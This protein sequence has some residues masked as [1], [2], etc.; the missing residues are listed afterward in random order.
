[1]SFG[2]S[3]GD[4]VMF[5]RFLVQVRGALKGDSG[6]QIQ[7]SRAMKQC[8]DF[9][10]ILGDVSRLDLSLASGTFKERLRECSFDTQDVIKDFRETVARYEKS[11]GEASTR[12]KLTSAP[13]KIQ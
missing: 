8:T 4:I 10:A 9:E 5:G 3:P 2:F 12:G 6:S 1:M 11:M 13:R 7:Y